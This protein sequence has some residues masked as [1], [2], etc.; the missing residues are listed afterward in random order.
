MPQTE[1]EKNQR[2]PNPTEG[3]SRDRGRHPRIRGPILVQCHSIARTLNEGERIATYAPREM[4]R[5]IWE[6]VK[7]AM[8]DHRG[9][10]NPYPVSLD[11]PEKPISTQAK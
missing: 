3:N 8:D 6:A 9:W 4:R 10:R 2:N 1:P 5:I 7:K 11:Y